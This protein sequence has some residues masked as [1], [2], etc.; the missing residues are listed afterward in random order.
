MHFSTITYINLTDVCLANN[1]E[2]CIIFT[3]E[4]LD[5]MTI[6][7]KLNIFVCWQSK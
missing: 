6:L 3:L 2:C 7:R 1:L 5:V 4:K